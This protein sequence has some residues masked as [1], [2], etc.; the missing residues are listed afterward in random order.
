MSEGPSVVQS[1]GRRRQLP[2]RLLDVSGRCVERLV[3]EEASQADQIARVVLQILVG[4]RVA[5]QVRMQLDA[6]D[7]TVLVAQGPKPT[8]GQRSSFAD[9]DPT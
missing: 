1:V 8:V 7:R 9:E 5:K 4:H 3:A 2:F 6:A